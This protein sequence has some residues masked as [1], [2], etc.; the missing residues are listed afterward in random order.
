MGVLT[1]G[2][3]ADLDLRRAPDLVPDDGGLR[4]RIVLFYIFLVAVLNLGLGFGVAVY[5]GRRYRWITDD[6]GRWDVYG[7]TGQP[8]LDAFS[9]AQE[10]ADETKDPAGRP[11]HEEADETAA[12]SPHVSQPGDSRPGET[13]A[14]L[15]SAEPER[16]KSAGEASIEQFQNEVEQYHDKL[17][18]ADQQLRANEEYPDAQAIEACLGSLLEATDEYLKGRGDVHVEFKEA[19]DQQPEFG[20]VTD[21]VQAAVE[22]QDAQIQST[23]AA[24]EGF[25]YRDNL[26]DGCRSVLGETSRMIDANH[27]LRDTLDQAQVGATRAERRL[28]EIDPTE[29]EDPL[30]GVNNRAGAEASLAQWWEKDPHRVRQFSAAMVDVD[31]FS[32]INEQYGHKVGD[33]ILRMVAQLLESQ[34]RSDCTVS[35]FSGQ[36][37][38][39]LFPDSDVR[40][41]TN[42]AE[43][44]RQMIEMTHFHYKEHDIQVTASCAVVEATPED[45]ADALISRA[46]A[47]LQEAKRYGRNR[48]FLHEGS[49]PTPVVPPNFS[50]EQKSVTL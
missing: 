26:G 17:E 24:I 1:P 49:Y 25:D 40:F 10:L 13:A 8:D 27:H 29:C 39:Y 45:T 16:P 33:K 44:A 3:A 20:A 6:V 22:Q 37:F 36:R 30:T 43:R 23:Q 12:A 15:R 14:Q 28:D 5:L 41:T 21:N 7:D 32:Q 50:L 9:F 47:T 34:G 11:P 18:Q 35:R 38:L 46:E 48:T 42:I 4:R 19:F 2:A 31:H